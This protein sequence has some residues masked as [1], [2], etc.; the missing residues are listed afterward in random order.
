MPIKKDNNGNRKSVFATGGFNQNVTKKESVGH[1][2]AS[3]ATKGIKLAQFA[4]GSDSRITMTQPMFSSPLHTPQNWQ[5]PSKRREIYQQCRHF[6]RTEPKIGAGIDFYSQFSMNNF[7]LECKSKKTL[8]IFEKIAKDLRINHWSKLISHEYFMLGDV[9]VFTEIECPACNGTG[10]D[11][12]GKVCNHPDGTIKRIIVLNPDWIEVKQSV[13]AGD[14]VIVL[15]P[16]EELKTIVSKRDPKEIYDR[17]PKKLIELVT[18]GKPIQ[19]SNRCVSHLKHNECP[20]ADY[21]V[22]LI[23][24]LLTMLAY[25]TKLI[26][27]N[28]IV[29]ERL[30]LPI[31]VVKIGDKDRPATAEDIADVGNQLSMVANDPNQTLVT[32]HAFEYE[33]YGACFPEDENIEV[34]TENGWKKHQDIQENEKLGTINSLTGKLELQNYIEKFEYDY[35][36][37]IYGGLYNFKSKRMN[38]PVTPN[39]RMFT[40]KSLKH[41][42]EIIQSQDVKGHYKML[43]QIEWDGFIPENLPY[44]N[45]DKLKHLAL[46]EFLEFS[47]YYLSEGHLQIERN[48]GLSEGKQVRAVG[49]T[50]KKY[51]KCY[52]KIDKIVSTVYPSYSIHSDTRGPIDIDTFVVNSADIARFMDKEFGHGSGEKSI[53]KWILEL[54]KKYL[55]IMFDSMMLGD[56]NVIK[57]NCGSKYKYS[58]KSKKL[59]DNVFDIVMKLGFSPKISLENGN[60][61]KQRGACYRIFWTD[62]KSVNEQ[63]IGRIERLP[64][65]GKVWCYSVPNKLLVV[66]FYG[67]MFV[68][69]NSGKIHNITAEL[70]FVGKEILDGLMLNQSLL[71]GE[72]TSY[73]SA[74][75]GVET[76]IRRLEGWRSSLAEWIES[77]IFLPIAMMRGFVDEEES[78]ELGETVYLYPKIKWNDLNLRD[79]SSQ[80]QMLMQL[81]DKNLISIQTLLSEFDLNY[82]HEVEKMREEQMMMSSLPGAAAGGGG[83]GMGGGPPM[84]PMGGGGG[85]G[86]GPPGMDLGGGP[87]GPPPGGDMGAP[88]GGD[89]GAGAAPPA[90]GPPGTATAGSIPSNFKITKRGKGAKEPEAAPVPPPTFIKLTKLEQQ[91]HKIIQSAKI[92]LQ[93]YGQYQVKVA[94]QDQ[95][96]LMDFA[97]PT[98]GIAIEAD[99]AAWHE[100]VES[101]TRDNERDKALANYGWRVLRFK[102]KAIEQNPGEVAK[103]ILAHVKDAEKRK[104]KRKASGESLIKEASNFTEMYKVEM[105]NDMGWIFYIEEK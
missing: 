78:A 71:N 36:S 73:S 64:Y 39:H 101:K 28:W 38:I 18:S 2:A 63:Q 66:R 42:Y 6:Y 60:Q 12:E 51:S 50:Q 92:P 13:L 20:Y 89:M 9:F 5:T 104:H 95:P 30:I 82:D 98:L 59:A 55:Q 26:T 88:P 22:S 11:K 46:E 1:Y 53:P 96:Y 105:E 10:M 99:G 8:K 47:G 79:N 69:G 19:L 4:G 76:L 43:S 25:K 52:S 75:V 31:R 24:R 33:W 56:G 100:N 27:A 67:R 94:G 23:Q 57:M 37:D 14:P 72:M 32:H 16:D 58:T 80:L 97:F 74:Q 48:K 77:R 68:I 65:K 93:L 70:E 49:I 21:G 61:L 7:K 54:P 84:P 15:V 29:A 35:D 81:Q 87:G 85:G 40:R 86:G 34:F 3:S 45:I 17:L 91:M 44:M 102:E 103:M 62:S 90:G 41:N 83:G